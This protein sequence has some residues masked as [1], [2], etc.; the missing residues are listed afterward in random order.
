MA[1]SALS[2]APFGLT[3]HQMLATS[4]VK[5]AHFEDL[6]VWQK[7]RDLS[8]AVYS[9]SGDGKF[10]RD[11][12]LRDQVRRAVVSIMSNIAEGF[13]RYSRTEFRHFLSIARGSAAEVRSQ[14][15]LAHRLGYIPEAE[16]VALNESCLEISRM[17]AK[18]R[19]TL[20]EP[21]R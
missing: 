10:A 7:S 9:A 14:L 19:S 4:T 6:R 21:R 11:P 15:H 13:E 16:Y 17:L 12:A 3:S 1:A 2:Y 20:S 18:L 8:L 5:L